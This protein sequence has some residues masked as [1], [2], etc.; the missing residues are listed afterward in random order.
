MGYIASGE[1]G[2]DLSELDESY[3]HGWSVGGFLGARNR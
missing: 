2:G 1:V 3:V